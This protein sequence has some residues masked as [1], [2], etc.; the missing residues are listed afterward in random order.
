MCMIYSPTFTNYI[1][2]VIREYYIFHTC[3]YI[4][5]IQEKSFSSKYSN[6]SKTDSSCAA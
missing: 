6:P 2:Y 4:L 5:L 1:F 3:V